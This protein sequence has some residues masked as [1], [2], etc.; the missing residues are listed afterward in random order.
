[1]FKERCAPA[2]S[3][4]ML[5]RALQL[6]ADPSCL[7]LSPGSCL[8]GEQ[9]SPG[10]VAALRGDG[11]DPGDLC[12]RAHCPD[13]PPGSHHRRHSERVRR[14]GVT[15]DASVCPLLPAQPFPTTLAPTGSYWWRYCCAGQTPNPPLSCSSMRLCIPP[16][17]VP[18]SLCDTGHGRRHWG[19]WGPRSEVPRGVPLPSAALFSV[20]L[21]CIFQSFASFSASWLRAALSILH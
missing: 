8:Q 11:P 4:L 17:T 16:G 15:P 1:M 7:S 6:S 20:P 14:P 2:F 13:Y 5:P 12:R 19:H 10:S 18:S 3:Q 9:A 21:P